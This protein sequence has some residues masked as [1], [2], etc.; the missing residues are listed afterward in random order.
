MSKNYRSL[1][2]Y[3]HVLY[4]HE[5]YM[6]HNNDEQMLTQNKLTLSVI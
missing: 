6:I 2:D 1:I 5:F 3:G 4:A